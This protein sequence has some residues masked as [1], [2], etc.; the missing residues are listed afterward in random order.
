MGCD[1]I[2]PKLLKNCALALYQPL[3][4]LFSLSLL[5]NYLPSEWRTHLIEPIFKSGNRNS[6]RNYRP[7]S[8]LCAVS[9]VVERLV[10]NGIVD[11][12][13]NSVSIQQ[14]GFLRGRS[15]LQQLLIMFNTLICP[16]SQTDVLYLDFRK[17]FDSVYHNELLHKL[18][19]FGI[20]NNLWLW[21][22]A[23]L[24]G[25]LQYV[26]VGQSVSSCLPVVSGVPQGSILGP[27]L[28]L[29]FIND[30]PTSLETS[31]VFLYAD[32]AKCVLPISSKVTV[33]IFKMILQDCLSDVAGGI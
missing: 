30:L 5:Q 15:A 19:N 10:Y 23:Y 7:I 22:K 33:F 32:D 24:T 14:F 16:G 17:A 21:I 12:V 9:K 31:M 4:H 18:W 20:T 27:L 1:G 29:I 28:F 11:F 6:V 2:S 8:L 26:S 13:S 25:R 3:H